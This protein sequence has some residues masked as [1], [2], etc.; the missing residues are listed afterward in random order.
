MNYQ[1]YTGIWEVTMAC[2]MRCKHCGSSC[3]DKLPGELTTE[4]A[5]QLCD[6]L[7]ELGMKYITLS[8]GEPTL[9]EDIF[10]I[11]SRLRKNNV[12]PNMITN[13]WN[14]TE[15]FVKKAKDAGI[16]TVAISIDG[17]EETH[18][19]I[20]RPGSYKK[21]MEAFNLL[22][23]YDIYTSAI[24]TVNK[25]NLPEL[26]E[27]KEIFINHDVNSW[28]IQLGLPMGN[29]LIND[30]LVTEP[31]DMKKI[32]DFAYNNLNDDRIRI[33]FGDCVG[34]YDIKSTAVMKKAKRTDYYYWQGC[35]AGKSSIGILHNGDILGCTSI[36]DS[37]FIEGNICDRSLKSIW[38]DENSFLWSRTL[39]KE[40]LSG[41][42]GK[43]SYGD[44]CLG[45]C[46]N[47]RLCME[48]DI[49]QSNRY[50]LY[51]QA[52]EAERNKLTQFNNVYEL[53]LASQQL[54]NK[55]KYQIAQIILERALN[56]D[57]NNLEVLKLLG[58]VN[59]RLQN[60]QLAK[61]IN[62]KVLKKDSNS[63]YAHKGL[64]LTLCKLGETRKG[65]EHLYKAIGLCD[66]NYMDPY[67]DCAVTL[68]ENNHK[69]EAINVLKKA[70]SKS[71]KFYE[72]HLAIYEK[73]GIS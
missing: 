25:K 65:L 14:I 57:E 62:E 1:L 15:E 45:G 50:C 44:V 49:Y 43:C 22:S 63:P 4:K 27:L 61:E 67:Y 48:K 47:T 21:S 51:Y 32:V 35:Q 7:G 46:T 73:L 58:Y 11:I 20:R 55:E 36:R 72:E 53:I 54:I 3:T 37:E 16:G 6:E 71:L 13:G 66:E 40:K 56:L 41:F 29:L 38:E 19:Y 70:K 68:I 30:F 8:G 28:Q 26:D 24:T 5:L 34:Y 42:C 2:N 59:Y 60:Y 23:N 69:E 10:Q 64:G 31:S 18:D 12:I 33:S 52:I 9:R 17:L 39:K